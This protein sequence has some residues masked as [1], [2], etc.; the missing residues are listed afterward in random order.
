MTTCFLAPDPIQSTQ[1]IPGGN[2]PANGAKLFVYL[3]GTSTKTTVY[4]DNAAGT[5]WTN[6]IVLDSGGNLPSGGEVWIP[7]G[8]TIKAVLAP[9]NDT[10][11]P[12]SPYWTKDNLSGINDIT[13]SGGNTDWTASQT[14]VFLSASSFSMTGDQTAAG[15]ADPNR[16]MKFT[17]TGP[18]ATAYGVIVSRAFA[19]GSTQVAMNMT[20]GALDAG[21]SAGFYGINSATNPSTPIFGGN[22]DTVSTAAAATTNIFGQGTDYVCITGTTGIFAFSTAAFAGQEV[23]CYF[24]ST[25]AVASSATLTAVNFTSA[26]G[27][28]VKVRA[29]SVSQHRIVSIYRSSGNPFLAPQ[30]STRILAGPASGTTSAVPAFRAPV[31]AEAVWTLITATTVPV[32]TTA[33]LDF[34]SG[35]PFSS[36]AYD[37]YQLKLVNVVPTTDNNNLNLRFATSA[38]YLTSTGAL[39]SYTGLVISD[40]GGTSAAGTS[41][42]NQIVIAP[43]VGNGGSKGLSGTINFYRPNVT[44]FRPFIDSFLSYGISGNTITM[45][46]IVGTLNE[47]SVAHTGFGISF[48]TGNISTGTFYLY[49]ARN[50]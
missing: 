20:V 30:A 29:D 10:D 24:N 32:N 1:F 33:V 42:A 16:R 38:A 14:P 46:N 6:P 49:G 41:I 26:A 17:V 12:A 34:F 4:K 37:M 21:L 39:Y 7:Q 50:S 47:T 43:N 45:A 23:T 40:N 11:P 13:S 25:V 35:G 22:A 3:A 8:I 28:V 18:P 15:T 31:G 5:S 44:S 27:D 9:S 19:T 48:N 36:S 2:T